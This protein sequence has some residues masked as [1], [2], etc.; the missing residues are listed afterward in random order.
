MSNCK[1]SEFTE[2]EILTSDL[3]SLQWALDDL[4]GV[5][6]DIQPDLCDEKHELLS[7]VD[8]IDKLIFVSD[9]HGATELFESLTDRVDVIFAEGER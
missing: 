2:A 9:L 4:D 6:A 5:I 8:A 7:A 1:L 3:T